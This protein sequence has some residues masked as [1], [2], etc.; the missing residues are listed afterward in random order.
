MV[1]VIFIGKINMFEFGFGLY[2]FNEVYGVMCNLYDLM[3]SVGGSSGGMVVVFVLWMLLVVDGSD[4]GGLLCNL[5]VFCNIYG[6][7]LL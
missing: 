4:F 6:F 2:M 7:C 1:G 5:V 3:K